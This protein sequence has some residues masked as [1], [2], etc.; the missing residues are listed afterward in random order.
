[1]PHLHPF[2]ESFWAPTASN[3]YNIGYSVLHS[4][5]EQ[6][7]AENKVIVDY[8]KQRINAEKIHATLLASITAPTTPFENDIGGA[9]KKCFEVVCAESQDSAKEHTNRADNLNTTTLDPLVQFFNRYD[10]II[11]QAKRTVESQINQFNLACKLMEEA[12]V[13]YVN[14][15][16]TMLIVQ[17]DYTDVKM[18]K[19]LQFHT[20]D[21]AWAWF[22][23]LFKEDAYTK[24]QVVDLL[25]DVIS[26]E[27]AVIESLLNIQFLKQEDDKYIKQ[28]SL[29]T[30][31]ETENPA[32]SESKGFSG[33]LG[34]WGGQ[35]QIKKEDILFDMMEADKAYQRSVTQAELARTQTEQILYVHY[36][37]ME[38]LELE[39]IQTIK[40]G[41]HCVQY[42]SPHSPNLTIYATAFIS[43]AASLSN[44]IP[45]CKETFDNMML[46]QETL[47]PDKDVQF[48][49]EQYRTGQYC[50]KPI[51]YENYFHSV[52]AGTHLLAGLLLLQPTLTLYMYRST[53][54]RFTRRNYKSTRYNGTTANHRGFICD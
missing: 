48:I 21:H 5:L 30:P 53:I 23:D 37:E 12:K 8:I 51:L 38:S 50:P 27:E 46:Y 9:L 35:Q 42:I 31:G 1:M 39:R 36:Q 33:F 25:K 11:T 54:W 49:V 52:A 14:R 28:Q 17:P 20:R 10:R 16:K 13:F 24:E 6:S 3:D 26:D 41:T 15:C 44:T 22:T 29:V 45:R 32:V 4:K 7:T 19:T 43:M 40:Q 2:Q 34:R 18:G 47:K